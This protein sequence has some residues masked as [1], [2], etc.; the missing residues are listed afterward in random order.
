MKLILKYFPDLTKQ[1]IE[2]IDTKW[3]WGMHRPPHENL[4]SQADTYKSE[5]PN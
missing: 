4:N 1:Q 3:A 2:Q 5:F